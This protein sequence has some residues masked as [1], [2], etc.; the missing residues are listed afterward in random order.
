MHKMHVYDSTCLTYVILCVVSFFSLQS[1]YA[2]LCSTRLCLEFG[3]LVGFFETLYL[4]FSHLSTV[5]IAVKTQGVK[6][7]S[8]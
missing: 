1:M 4:P 6:T 5:K 3:M 8:C 2:H 7:L